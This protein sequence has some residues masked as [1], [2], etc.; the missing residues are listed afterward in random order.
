MV[1]FGVMPE[2]PG[3]AY[4]RHRK[5]PHFGDTVITGDTLANVRWAWTYANGERLREEVLKMLQEIDYREAN[6]TGK[7]VFNTELA[8]WTF[9]ISTIERLKTARDMYAIQPMADAIN[10]LLKELGEK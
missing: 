10:R 8:T 6:A 1:N 2:D 3:A 9:R 7:V 5:G 4:R